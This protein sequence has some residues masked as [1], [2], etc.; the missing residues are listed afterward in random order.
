MIGSINCFCQES[1]DKIPIAFDGKTYGYIYD[2]NNSPSNNPQ[3]PSS[4]SYR[5]I[6]G[7]SWGN[8]ANDFRV[9]HRSHGGP[10]Y[11]DFYHGLRLALVP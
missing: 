3:G 11:K 2:Y 7:G 10:Y 8:V 6:R 9:A 1:S 4:G 5:V